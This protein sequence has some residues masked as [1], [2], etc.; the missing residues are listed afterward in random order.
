MRFFLCTGL[1]LCLTAGLAIADESSSPLAPEKVAANQTFVYGQGTSTITCAP[2]HYC[3]LALQQGEVIQKLDQPDKKWLVSATTY[4][5]GQFA[6]PVV[7]L[8]PSVADLSSDLDITTDRHHYAVKLVS[9]ATKWTGLS[10]FSYPN[11]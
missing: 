1:A 9:S 8:S 5:A 2:T 6:T 11:P 4:G 3:A 7:I 10:A